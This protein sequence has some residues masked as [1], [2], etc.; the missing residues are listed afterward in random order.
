[1]KVASIQLEIKDSESKEQRI[2]RATDLVDR[3]AQDADLILLPEVWA[4]GYF[5]F[6]KYKEE[7]E[8]LDGEFVRFFAAKAKQHGVYLFAG[9][10]IEVK[11][12]N[13]YNTSI[14]F[15]R[16][17]MLVGTYQ[18]THLFR[19]GSKEGELLTRG[20]GAK[21]FDTEFGKVGLTTCYDLRFP[22]LYRQQV[23]LG[24]QMFLVTSAWP[25]QRLEHWKLFNATRA[26]ENQSFLI[27]CNC[28]GTTNNVLLGGHSSIVDPWGIT[29]ATAGEQETI[30]KSEIDPSE[31]QRIR[32]VFPSLK[33]RVI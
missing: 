28:V 4:T 11:D 20:D 19:Y 18:K 10:F 31:V 17:G 7:A 15:D 33:H 2:G 3:A 25:H 8:P 6:D 13:Y 14:L 5:N 30:V 21:V 22:E 1:M 23:D 9:S 29:L 16:Q 27:S 32:D 12:G 26:L 24:A